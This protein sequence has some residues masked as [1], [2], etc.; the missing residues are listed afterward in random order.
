MADD[1][2]DIQRVVSI[3]EEH[4]GKDNAISSREINERIDADNVG[5]FPRTREIVREILERELLPIASGND[6]YYVIETREEL[7][8]EIESINRRIGNIAE[9]RVHVRRAALEHVEDIENLESTSD[10]DF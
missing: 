10:D 8:E 7:E 5:S 6:G 1:D 4:R 3:L 9:R 2:S